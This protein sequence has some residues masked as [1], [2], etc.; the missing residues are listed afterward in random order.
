MTD[1]VHEIT[2]VK[3]SRKPSWLTKKNA[4]KASALAVFGSAVAL[5]AYDKVANRSQD[6]DTEE[7]ET[8]ES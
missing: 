6:S 7:T 1:T 4:L 5:V 3:K 2:D 8:T